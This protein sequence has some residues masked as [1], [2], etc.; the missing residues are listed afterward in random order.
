MEEARDELPKVRP[1]GWQ[2]LVHNRP[3]WHR[4]S[5]GFRAWFETPGSHLEPCQC[6]WAPELGPHYRL[7]QRRPLTAL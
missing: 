3:Q 5:D 4:R 1:E 2:V 7:A 6:G